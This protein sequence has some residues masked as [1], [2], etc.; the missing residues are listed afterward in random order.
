ME[1]GNRDKSPRLIPNC[2]NPVRI[3]LPKSTDL[4]ES[5][6]QRRSGR[7]P[8]RLLFPFVPLSLCPFVPFFQRT[9]PLTLIYIRSVQFHAMLARIAHDLGWLIK[10]HRLAVDQRRREGGG[11]VAFEPGRDVDQ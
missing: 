5:K 8:S 7:S 1:L 11:V 9:I 6:P 10:P 2:R 3:H 4:P